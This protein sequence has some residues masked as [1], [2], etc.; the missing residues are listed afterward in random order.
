[1]SVADIISK[2]AAA[3]KNYR[4]AVRWYKE[5]INYRNSV[6]GDDWRADGMWLKEDAALAYK[7]VVDDI[8]T[9][10]NQIEKLKEELRK[11]RQE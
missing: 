3:R 2:L 8:K 4:C 1:M 7:E 11:E 6:S 5:A 10:R 9:Y